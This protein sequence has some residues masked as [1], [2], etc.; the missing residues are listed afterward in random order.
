MGALAGFVVGVGAYSATHRGHFDGW[1]AARWG[2]LGALVGGTLGVAFEAAG[3]Y[4][5]FGV[6]IAEG[7]VGGAAAVQASPNATGPANRIAGNAF[8]DQIADEFRQNGYTVTTEVYKRTPF[9][10]RF[11]DI[12]VARNGQTL[13]GIETKVGGSRYIAEQR[14]KDAWLLRYGALNDPNRIPYPVVVVRDR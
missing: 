5:L 13:G 2:A 10:K 14:A 1:E 8:R 4:G 3:A 11:I 7:E 9:G 6:G 12:E